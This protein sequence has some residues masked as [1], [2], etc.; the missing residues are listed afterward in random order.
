[1]K[2]NIEGT[3]NIEVKT[4]KLEI[5]L[6][7]RKLLPLWIIKFSKFQTE[8]V[9]ECNGKEW[10]E[11]RKINKTLWINWIS[12]LMEIKRKTKGKKKEENSK[13]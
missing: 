2:I 12:L 9:S 1:M 7:S 10:Q 8:P 5:Y 4:R 6:S 13:T 3:D 11:K